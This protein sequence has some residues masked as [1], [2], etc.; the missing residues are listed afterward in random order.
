MVGRESTEERE[1]EFFQVGGEWA[2]FRLVVGTPP[3]PLIG[4]TLYVAAANCMIYVLFHDPK[5]LIMYQSN[6]NQK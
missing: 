1:G 3:I 5:P 2:N 6:Y 4:K